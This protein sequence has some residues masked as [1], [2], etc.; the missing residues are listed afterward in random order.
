M[1]IKF[2]LTTSILDSFRGDSMLREPALPD[3][4][5]ASPQE[6]IVALYRLAVLC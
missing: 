4:D 2:G 1:P 5:R 6:L 3:H